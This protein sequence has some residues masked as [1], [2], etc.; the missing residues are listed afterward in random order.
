MALDDMYQLLDVS[1]YLLENNLNVFHVVRSG[2]GF[3]AND[4]G[5]AFVASVLNEILD[6]QLPTV[7]HTEIQVKNLGDPTDFDTIVL[8]GKVGTR[9]GSAAPSSL[10]AEVRFPR[11]RTDMRDGFKRFGGIAEET[12]SGQDFAAAFLTDV[13][14]IGAAMIA[15]WEKAS[16]PGVSVCRYVIIKRICTVDVAPLPCPSYRLP[17]TD[18]ELTFYQPTASESKTTVR[19]QVSRRS[20]AT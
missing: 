4:V 11:K 6:I 18:A 7:T 5:Q 10:A 2:S 17:E 9:T 12:F 1:N 19:T 13:D 20:A 15:Q 14:K 8:S 16:D 3:D